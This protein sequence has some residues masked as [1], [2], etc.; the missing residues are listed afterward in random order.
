MQ[1]GTP[2]SGAA[3]V[4]I[5]TGLCFCGSYPDEQ[6][7]GSGPSWTAKTDLHPMGAMYSEGGRETWVNKWFILVY[8]FYLLVY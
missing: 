1:L 2:I 4:V 7:S 3:K 5:R 6:H 8:L